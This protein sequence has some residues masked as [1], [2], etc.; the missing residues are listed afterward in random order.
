MVAQSLSGV[1][2]KSRCA[3]L[4][5]W[6][7]AISSASQIRPK[8]EENLEATCKRH[9][10]GT[11]ISLPGGLTF[12]IGHH[13]RLRPGCHPQ[14]GSVPSPRAPWFWHDVANVGPSL[15]ARPMQGFPK[16][17]K[18]CTNQFEVVRCHQHPSATLHRREVAI[19][20]REPW[21]LLLPLS[22]WEIHS[23][24]SQASDVMA[25]RRKSKGQW[26]GTSPSA[27]QL[28]ERGSPFSPLHLPAAN[29]KTG[30]QASD[31]ASF[32]RNSCWV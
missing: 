11:Q 20:N 9:M 31:S 19:S 12:R 1:L 15:P 13:R 4:H 17:L 28:A 7:F 24:P 26:K 6:L 21:Q 16:D 3:A 8:R 22:P 25:E 23:P 5:L 32:Q 27:R 29:R 18:I 30:A 14:Q 10:E 2:L